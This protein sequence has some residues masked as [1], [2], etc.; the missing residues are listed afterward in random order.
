[1]KP[2]IRHAIFNIEDPSEL[3]KLPPIS[4]AFLAESKEN[5]RIWGHA[6]YVEDEIS[7]MLSC[8]TCSYKPVIEK[9]DISLLTL[10][11]TMRPIRLFDYVF[12]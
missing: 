1:M 9:S 5:G 7:E 2:Q 10:L 6:L 4:S 8:L 12:E 11:D 3:E